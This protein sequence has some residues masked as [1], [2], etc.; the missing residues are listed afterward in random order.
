MRPVKISIIIPTYNERENIEKLIPL[1]DVYLKGLDYEI[2]VVDDNSPDGTAAVAEAL[3]SKYPVRVVK[4]PRKMG[5]SSAIHS[6]IRVASGEAIVVMDA[7][8]QHSPSLIPRL[9]KRLEECD[10]VIASRYVRGGGVRGFTL[11]RRLMS[12]GA[13]LLARL[14]VRG[15]RGVKDPVSGYFAA[16]RELVASWS[17]LEPE[18]YKVL[19]EILGT[20]RPRRVC[21]EPYVFERRAA[22]ESKLGKRIVLSY[23]KTL[24]KLNKTGF[25]TLVLVAVGATAALVYLLISLLA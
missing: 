25:L 3:S 15:C 16:R 14:L 23:V 10:V 4:R 22:G 19:V 1:I 21:E 17:P 13:T 9:V 24:Y 18:G 7:D 11:W 12:I 5:L 2:I 8:F 6:G 20:L